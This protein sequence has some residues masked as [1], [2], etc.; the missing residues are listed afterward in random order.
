MVLIKVDMST[1]LLSSL[2]YRIEM[3][4]LYILLVWW[5]TG[6]LMFSTGV[7]LVMAIINTLMYIFH[8]YGVVKFIDNFRKMEVGQ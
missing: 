2:V 6:D 3:V 5:Y 8:H 4:L 7:S 1:V